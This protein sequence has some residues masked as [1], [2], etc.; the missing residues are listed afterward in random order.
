MTD[1]IGKPFTSFGM[2]RTIKTREAFCKLVCPG[3]SEAAYSTYFP[4]SCQ[5]ITCIR[6]GTNYIGI[7]ENMKCGECETRLK[8]IGLRPVK[9]EWMEPG[10]I[11]EGNFNLIVPT[12]FL[13]AVQKAAGI[14]SINSSQIPKPRKK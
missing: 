1:K 2:F 14:I 9:F 11:P 5:L 3:C 12:D 8:C 4:G 13:D 6:C 10:V 7:V